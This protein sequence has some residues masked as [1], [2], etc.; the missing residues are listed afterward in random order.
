[1]NLLNADKETLMQSVEDVFVDEHTSDSETS[2][3]EAACRLLEAA[4]KILAEVYPS[5]QIA[6][7]KADDLTPLLLAL[8]QAAE[9]VTDTIRR[10]VSALSPDAAPTLTAS[11][12]QAAVGLTAQIANDTE[13]LEYAA[14]EIAG[15]ISEAK[16]LREEI[17]TQ[18]KEVERR[19]AE[20]KALEETLKLYAAADRRIF[21]SLPR[22][23][24]NTERKLDD[25]ERVLQE[26][27][28][29]LKKLLEIH[30]QGFDVTQKVVE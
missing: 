10:T 24:N 13:E 18:G 2:R 14:E 8:R 9:S 6:N 27:D 12:N 29:E 17:I 15:K 5:E 28:E 16:K 25:A 3:Q 22:R 4:V 1:M 20:V 30:Q 23:M 21:N 19:Y 26:V 7:L 11:L